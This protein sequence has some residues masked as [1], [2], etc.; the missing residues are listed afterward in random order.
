MPVHP[1][2]RMLRLFIVSIVRLLEWAAYVRVVVGRSGGDVEEFDAPLPE[3]L[4][5]PLDFGQ[6]GLEWI[7]RVD[8]E[9]VG[10]RNRKVAG[11]TLAGT[12]I[13]GVGHTV[14]ATQAHAQERSGTD[15]RPDFPGDVSDKACTVLER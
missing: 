3:T 15:S 5:C 12:R 13:A 1:E 14:K 4:N 9:T 7:V 2:K 11:H 8:A 6:F 10:I